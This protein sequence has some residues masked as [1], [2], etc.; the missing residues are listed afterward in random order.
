MQIGCSKATR[1]GSKTRS[2]NVNSKAT[3]S[4]NLMGSR[5]RNCSEKP[6]PTMTG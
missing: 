3:P 1:S 6:K 5:I 4:P 2:L